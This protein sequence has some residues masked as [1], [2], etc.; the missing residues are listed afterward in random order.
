MP[1]AYFRD[2]EENGPAFPESSL[3]CRPSQLLLCLAVFSGDK[4]LLF[5]QTLTVYLYLHQL[6]AL[7]FSCCFGVNPHPSPLELTL[8]LSDKNL[9]LSVNLPLHHC[10]PQ[11][12]T[13]WKSRRN[14]KS[15][16]QAGYSFAASTVLSTW[17][18]TRL[19]SAN[20]LVTF[21]TDDIGEQEALFLQGVLSDLGAHVSI[22][23]VLK[24]KNHTSRPV[25]FSS[26]CYSFLLLCVFNQNCQTSRLRQI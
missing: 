17:L 24:K 19:T 22:R 7:L 3:P 1:R 26:V 13:S 2:H 10:S 15:F 9:G 6:F 20:V 16:I 11:G 8:R 21:I 18:W 5:S 23:K 25:C 14:S 4:G 12:S